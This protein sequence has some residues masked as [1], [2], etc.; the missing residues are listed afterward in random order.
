LKD[1]KWDPESVRETIRDIVDD[2]I[3]QIRRNRK[4]SHHPMDDYGVNS[5][6]FMGM[7]GVIALWTGDLGL[8]VYLWDCINEGASFP[9]IDFF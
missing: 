7:A 6:L 2:A 3:D 8:A 4:L 5:D 1:I 9:T